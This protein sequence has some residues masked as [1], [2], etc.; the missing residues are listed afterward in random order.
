MRIPVLALFLFL[1]FGFS[2][3]QARAQVAAASTPKC[4]LTNWDKKTEK[5]MEV[6]AGVVPPEYPLRH[7]P[8]SLIA[9]QGG[10]LNISSKDWNDLKSHDGRTTIHLLKFD[11]QFQISIGHIDS[12][13]AKSQVRTD[14][15]AWTSDDSKEI[16][17]GAFQKKFQCK[18]R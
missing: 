7:Q 15:T 11:G 16:G 10:A 17:I 5:W 9:W 8:W 13:N 12:S 6:W 2:A 18:L 4:V 3:N 14:A 1:T